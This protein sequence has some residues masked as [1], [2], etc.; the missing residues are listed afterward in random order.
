[1]KCTANLDDHGSWVKCQLCVFN[2]G[3]IL[4]SRMKNNDFEAVQ[5]I[6]SQVIIPILKL[7]IEGK[8]IGDLL[9]EEITDMDIG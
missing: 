9:K 8:D 3:T 5:S 1:M 6:A 4:L 2:S 7:S